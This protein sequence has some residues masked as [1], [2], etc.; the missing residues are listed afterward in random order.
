MHTNIV[1]LIV[2]DIPSLNIEEKHWIRCLHHAYKNGSVDIIKLILNMNIN[3][4]IFWNE[5]ALY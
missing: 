1:K 4:T 3:Q 2:N 5:E